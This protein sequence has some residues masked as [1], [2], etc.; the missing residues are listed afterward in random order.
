MPEASVVRPAVQETEWIEELDIVPGQSD[1]IRE[2]E[3]LETQIRELPG[4]WQL[5][6]QVAQAYASDGNFNAAARHLRECLNL[7]SEPAV[8]AGVF[9]NLGICLENVNN[10]RDAASAYEQS[11]FLLPNL[12]WGRY[13]LGTCWM[14]LGEWRLA[15]EELQHAVA[16]DDQ[17]P[18]GFRALRDA[19]QRAG[20]PK[21]AGEAHSRL[22][23]LHPA[24]APGCSFSQ[25]N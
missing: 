17:Q 21:E 10:W 23:E 9:F 2:I 4:H 16:L 11:L 15:I 5:R 22:L 3:L 19:L 20:M 1:N 24:P 25:V 6:L 8:V 13:K 7:V 18:E 14:R 12:F